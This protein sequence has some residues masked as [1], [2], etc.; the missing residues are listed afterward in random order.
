M[1]EARFKAETLRKKGMLQ[2]LPHIKRRKITTTALAAAPA[3]L[4]WLPAT[5][6]A[7]IQPGH[8]RDLQ[9]TSIDGSRGVGAGGILRL[10]L[11]CFGGPGE[12]SKAEATPQLNP[13]TTVP[14]RG[15]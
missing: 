8:T 7:R 15:C 13:L 12:C 5:R 10:R 3:K 9:Y 14:K 4:S 2:Q 6:D 11:R 1:P